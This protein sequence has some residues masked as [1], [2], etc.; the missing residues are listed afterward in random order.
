MFNFISMLARR[1]LVM[2][3]IILSLSAIILSSAFSA[4]A[5]AS[6]YPAVITKITDGDTVW[7]RTGA[8]RIKLRLLGIDTHE[9]TTLTR[10]L[11]DILYIV[12]Y[13]EF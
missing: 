3:G 5:L 4:L 9:N 10:L 1:I 2:S 12:R 13:V 6:T 8:G 7:V 11:G